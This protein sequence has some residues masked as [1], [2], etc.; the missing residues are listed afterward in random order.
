MM[1][2]AMT[3]MVAAVVV[4]VVMMMMMEFL[5]VN[6]LNRST[7][8]CFSSSKLTSP[9]KGKVTHRGGGG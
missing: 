4:V 1:M 5:V 3:E 6:Y 8:H 2:K 9:I 7:K